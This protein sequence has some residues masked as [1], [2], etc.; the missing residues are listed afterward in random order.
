MMTM[1]TIMIIIILLFCTAQWYRFTSA[2]S[3]RIPETCVEPNHCGTQWP[4]WMNG[5]HPTGL[6]VISICCTTNISS[7][8]TFRVDNNIAELVGFELRSIQ[9]GLT[10]IAA[11]HCRAC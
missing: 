5:Q 2:V 9:L 1:T 8:R 6:M 3:D 4:I 10:F 11:Q 7:C